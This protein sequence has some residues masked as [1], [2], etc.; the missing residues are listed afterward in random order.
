MLY[1]REVKH[2]WYQ[3]YQADFGLKHFK[4]VSRTLTEDGGGSTVGD[5]PT[6]PY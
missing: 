3:M 2:A 5:K 6:G 1:A 4:L